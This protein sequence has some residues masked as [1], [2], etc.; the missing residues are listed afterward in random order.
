MIF[1]RKWLKCKMVK[2]PS[3]PET[4]LPQQ[5]YKQVVIDQLAG[6]YILVRQSSL[7][8]EKL[9]DDNG[10]LYAESLLP[11]PFESNLKQ[12]YGWSCFLLGIFQKEHIHI[13]VKNGDRTKNWN[14]VDSCAIPNDNEIEMNT[15]PPLF[16]LVKDVHN[17]DFPYPNP[18]QQ[19]SK[20]TKKT[21]KLIGKCAVEHKPSN[22]NF[23]HF[24]FKFNNQENDHIKNGDS[25]W[26]KDAA[27]SFITMTLKHL[28][29]HKSPQSFPTIPEAAYCS[30]TT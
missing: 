26:K 11:E 16:L 28:L 24:Q 25:G 12:L 8:S 7:P 29:T 15:L 27:R 4:L 23:W 20:D 10:G 22:C 19:N 9:I 1:L 21:T 13:K 14:Y 17:K 30:V 3:Y 6:D 18:Q 5:G 2:V